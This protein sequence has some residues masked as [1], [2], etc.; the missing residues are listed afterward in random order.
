M[1]IEIDNSVP[2]PTSETRGRPAKYPIRDLE[3]GESFAVPEGKVQ[4]VR[5]SAQQVQRRNPGRQYSV[6]P[7]GDG[8]YRCWRIA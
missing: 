4:N 6:K 5:S 8:N 1:G 2:L 3:I 7:D